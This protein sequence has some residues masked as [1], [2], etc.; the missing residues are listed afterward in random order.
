MK[1]FLPRLSHNITFNALHQLPPPNVFLWSAP[2]PC[3]PLGKWLDWVPP[4][5]YQDTTHTTQHRWDQLLLL[6][7]SWIVTETWSTIFE[8]ILD[9]CGGPGGLIG[10]SSC[11]FWSKS[12]SVLKKSRGW[13]RRQSPCYVKSLR[14]CKRVTAYI[15]NATWWA[16]CCGQFEQFL[17]GLTPIKLEKVLIIWFQNCKISA[18]GI[19]HTNLPTLGFQPNLCFYE[20]RKMSLKS[21]Y[22]PFEV[23]WGNCY[24]LLSTLGSIAIFWPMT[25]ITT[26]GRYTKHFAWALTLMP[27]HSIAA[28]AQNQQIHKCNNKE[29]HKKH[30][31]PY[32]SAYPS[33]IYG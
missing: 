12:F 5:R 2:E 9:S 15:P 7:H 1:V 17:P 30:K 4:K 32:S 24:V 3:S 6:N 23:I 22:L 33:C 27:W 21:A 25:E 28:C 16:Q 26:E 10:I 31:F 11:L 20:T 8:Q 29:T 18:E 14:G 19:Y 13:L